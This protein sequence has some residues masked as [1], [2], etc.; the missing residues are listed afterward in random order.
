MMDEPPVAHRP[1]RSPW[2]LAVVATVIVAGATAAGAVIVRHTSGNGALPAG[3]VP[4]VT[5]TPAPGSCI[6]DTQARTVWNDVTRRL[7]TLVLHPDVTRIG[8]VAR[9]T[10]AQDI[11]LYLQQTL[12]DKHLTE[13]ERERLDAVHVIQPGCNGQPLL[14]MVTETLV[15]DDYLAADGHVDHVDAGVGHTHK[16]LE[17]YARTGATWLL[18]GLQPLDQPTPTDTGQTV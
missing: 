2:T 18:T 9:G 13:R 3:S 11:R 10:V 16:S 5:E 15:Q 12:L 1:R 8:T 6:D 17:T 14:V 7:D 4:G